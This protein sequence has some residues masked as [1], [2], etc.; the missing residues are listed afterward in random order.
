MAIDSQYEAIIWTIVG[1]VLGSIP[2]ALSGS[3]PNIALH[4]ISD[5]LKPLLANLTATAPE[6][7]VPSQLIEA[8]LFVVSTASAVVGAIA[9]IRELIVGLSFVT[10]FLSLAATM[11]FQNPLHIFPILFMFLI[12]LVRILYG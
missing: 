6:P 3:L 9:D 4:A 7:L 2:G 1:V 11:L 8:A 5:A 10:S 12:R